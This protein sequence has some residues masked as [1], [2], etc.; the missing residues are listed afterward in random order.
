MNKKKFEYQINKLGLKTE[1][2]IKVLKHI[3]ERNGRDILVYDFGGIKEL[4]NGFI[5]VSTRTNKASHLFYVL[6]E[7]IKN[8]D[9]S[10]MYRKLR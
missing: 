10:D 3:F 1:A 7:N 9:F 5:E 2:E 4:S 8:D 6:T